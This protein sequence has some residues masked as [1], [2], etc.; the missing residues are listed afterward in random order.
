MHDGVGVGKYFL[1]LMVVSDDV[2]QSEPFCFLGFLDAGDAAIDGD[3]DVDLLV[4]AKV[5]KCLRI[6]AVPFVEPIRDVE[7]RLGTGDT[8]AFEQDRRRAHPVDVVVAVNADRL[9]VPHGVDDDLSRAFDPR[10]QS[11]IGK[12]RK[13]SFEIFAAGVFVVDAAVDEQLPDRLRHAERLRQRDRPRRILRAKTPT[14]SRRR[15][16]GG[17]HV[18]AHFSPARNSRRS[19]ASC[20]VRSLRRPSGISEVLDG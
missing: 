16:D 14:L 18:V 12:R 3:D 7:A 11:R 6:D 9:A 17:S 13:A 20:G 4:F 8:E 10:K 5:P 2:T 1:R 19:A 15:S